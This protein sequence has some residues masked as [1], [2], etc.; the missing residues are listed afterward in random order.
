MGAAR[1]SN[2]AELLYLLGL[3]ELRR[4]TDA[5]R[6]TGVVHR[7]QNTVPLN[8][9]REPISMLERSAFLKKSLCLEGETETRQEL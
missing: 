6:Q 7:V 9:L 8:P 3:R 2:K 5:G 1:R 4:R